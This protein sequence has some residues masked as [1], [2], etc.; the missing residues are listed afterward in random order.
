MLSNNCKNVHEALLHLSSVKQR[1]EKKSGP[2]CRG[3]FLPI[4]KQSH[5]NYRVGLGGQVGKFLQ[6]VD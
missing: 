3:I 5:G 1:K 4:Q 6:I 2:Y